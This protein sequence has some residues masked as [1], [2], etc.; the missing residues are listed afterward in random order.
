LERSANL[1]VLVDEEEQH[2]VPTRKK[3]PEKVS[4]ERDLGRFR[5]I[6]GDLGRLKEI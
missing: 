4:E 5:E 1:V 6:E 2:F 3:Q